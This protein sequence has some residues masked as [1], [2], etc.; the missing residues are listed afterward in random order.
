MDPDPPLAHD[1]IDAFFAQRNDAGF[2]NDA[3]L[4][5]LRRTGGRPVLAE[6]VLEAWGEGRPLPVKRGVWSREEDGVLER[7]DGRAL[8]ELAERH[9]LDGWGGVTERMN[10]LRAWGRGE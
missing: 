2:E 8:E 4:R 1:E 3:I 10:Y 7:G 5:A 6:E 9:S